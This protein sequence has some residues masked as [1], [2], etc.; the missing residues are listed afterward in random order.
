MQKSEY[1]ENNNLNKLAN[2]VVSH[3]TNPVLIIIL[4]LSIRARH[5]G[6]IKKVVFKSMTETMK[7]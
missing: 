1:L 4:N 3:L 7:N 5:G 2:G 6:A